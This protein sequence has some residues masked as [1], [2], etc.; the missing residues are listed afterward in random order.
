MKILLIYYTGT[1][2]TRYLAN[3]IA[4][5]FIRQ[6]DAVNLIEIDCNTVPADTSGYDLIGFSYPIYGFNSPAPFNRYVKK[7]NFRKGQKYFIFK[8]SGETYA[9]NNASSRILIKR[10]NKFKAY[11]AG[12]YHFVMPYN[13][14]FPYERDFIRQ[15]FKEN[16]KL[17][18][19]MMYN[20]RNGIVEEIKSNFIY[21]FLAFL[22]SI[23]KIGGNV[24]SFLYR[25]DKKKC[26]GC[27]KCVKSCPRQNIYVKNGLVKF[28]HRCDMCMRCSFFCPADAVKIGFLNGWKVNGDYGLESIENDRSPFTP[29]ITGNS[30]GFYRCF[31]KHFKEIDVRHEEIF[32]LS[33]KD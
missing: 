29:Y 7:L 20:L 18:D 11:L 28:H 25:V 1:F 6:G 27:G 23:Q 4:S 19:I 32:G 17:T 9:V 13:I 31:I 33:R 15:I 10:M 24:N 30:R 8:N 2:N 3:K 14:H 22:V 21:N 5:R 16:E 12:E 26:I